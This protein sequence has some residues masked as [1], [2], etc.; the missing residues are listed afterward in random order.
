MI[1]ISSSFLKKDGVDLD[2]LDA[3]DRRRLSDVR[4]DFQAQFVGVGLGVVDEL[5]A[6]L[7]QQCF[8]GPGVRTAP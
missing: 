7:A 6:P 5:D 3:L 4:G 2:N 1:D 8:H